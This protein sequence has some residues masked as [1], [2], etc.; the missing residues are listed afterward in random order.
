VLSVHVAPV[1]RNERKIPQPIQYEFGSTTRA[2]SMFEDG[3]REDSQDR[4][5]ISG[6]DTV[7]QEV[8]CTQKCSRYSVVGLDTATGPAYGV[9][10]TSLTKGIE[11]MTEALARREMTRREI[12]I[13]SFLK[14]S[15]YFRISSPLFSALAKS[16]AQDEDIVDLCSSIRRGQSAGAL[17]PFVVQ[18][19]LRNSPESPLAEYFPSLTDSPLP[20]AQA[21]EAFR[22]FCLDR[23]SQIM[24]L[25]SWRTVNTNLAEKAC[26]LLP[27]IKHV[28]GLSNEPLTLFG[29][30]L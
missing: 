26:S 15:T 17:L 29:N 25:L 11:P 14:E 28:A 4:C 2:R 30:L 22:E 8:T 20:P 5:P 23:R 13:Q 27:A 1:S 9:G 16:C 18:Y 19:L 21:F 12:T 7:G 3:E 10:P 6:I 24:E